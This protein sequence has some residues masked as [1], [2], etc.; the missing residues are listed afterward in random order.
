MDVAFREFLGIYFFLYQGKIFNRSVATVYH[1]NEE[2]GE[3][4]D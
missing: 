4:K 3:K 1:F 2:K